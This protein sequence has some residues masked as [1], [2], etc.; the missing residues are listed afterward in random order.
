MY[1]QQSY[2]K[3]RETFYPLPDRLVALDGYRGMTMGRRKRGPLVIGQRVRSNFT[4]PLDNTVIINTPDGNIEEYSWNDSTR[5]LLWISTGTFTVHTSAGQTFTSIHRMEVTSGTF[6]IV[7]CIT[8]KCHCQ[9]ADENH[10]LSY[11]HEYAAPDWL[12]VLDNEWNVINSWKCSCNVLAAT[13]GIIYGIPTRCPFKFHSDNQPSNHLRRFH[14][15]GKELPLISHSNM[16]D[17]RYVKVMH[18]QSLDKTLL[19]VSDPSANRLFLFL[20]DE[21]CWEWQPV[22]LCQVGPV[23]ISEASGNLYAVVK[24]S[25]VNQRGGDA[26]TSSVQTFDLK[27]KAMYLRNI[28]QFLCYTSTFSLLIS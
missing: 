17:P 21:L 3:E 18:H 14:V 20:D 5:G 22:G 11:P 27:G 9:G 16:K 25:N 8:G 28:Q 10:D 13:N 6:Y 7:Q 23:A 1:F 4:L 12:Y 19:F 26:I 2:K 24:E 15:G